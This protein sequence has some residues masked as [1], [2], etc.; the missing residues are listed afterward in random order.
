MSLLTCFNIDL[1]CLLV[2]FLVI[3]IIDN[4]T[5]TPPLLLYIITC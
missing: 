5:K 4:F 1:I 3:L 2:S